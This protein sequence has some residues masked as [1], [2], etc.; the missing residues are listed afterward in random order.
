MISAADLLCS[1]YNNTAM[2]ATVVNPPS[3]HVSVNMCANIWL[4]KKACALCMCAGVKSCTCVK[5]DV[6]PNDIHPSTELTSHPHPQL[7]ELT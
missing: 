1:L 7:N 3:L 6:D 2:R 5:D 4:C